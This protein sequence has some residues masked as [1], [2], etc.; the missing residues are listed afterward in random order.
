[1]TENK[2]EH[3][4][5]ETGFCEWER[6]EDKEN[7]KSAKVMSF[8]IKECSHCGNEIEVNKSKK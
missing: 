3:N 7:K 4:Y 1:M 2:C 6:P 8:I 5:K